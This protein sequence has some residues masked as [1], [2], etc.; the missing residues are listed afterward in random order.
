MR[1]LGG[2][3]AVCQQPAGQPLPSTVTPAQPGTG[4]HTAKLPAPCMALCEGKDLQW[5]PA[6]S[7]T[8][9]GGA[10]QPWVRQPSVSVAQQQDGGSRV[11]RPQFEA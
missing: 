5:H 8:Q 9:Q 2:T 4:G 1:L 10:A 11:G 7:G 6:L 3:G